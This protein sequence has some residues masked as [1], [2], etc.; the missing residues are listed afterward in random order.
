MTS[1]NIDAR[2][3][4]TPPRLTL[5]TTEEADS[6]CLTPTCLKAQAVIDSLSFFL[7]REIII[8]QAGNFF[9]LIPGVFSLSRLSEVRH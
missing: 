2:T 4:Q 1:Q 9:E 6:W 3:P 5:D 8:E 7:F